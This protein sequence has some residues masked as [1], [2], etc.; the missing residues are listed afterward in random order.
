MPCPSFLKHLL[1]FSPQIRRTGLIKEPKFGPGCLIFEKKGLRCYNAA[2]RMILPTISGK[3]LHHPLHLEEPSQPPDLEDRLAHNDT[4]DEDIPPFDAAVCALGGIA[5]GAL[6]NDN[7]GLLVLDLGKKLGQLLD[8]S[9]SI[10]LPS[11]G[12]S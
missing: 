5:V 12:S 9:Y 6:A 10:S 1:E 2:M 7:V 3:S 8:C 11:S 4:Q